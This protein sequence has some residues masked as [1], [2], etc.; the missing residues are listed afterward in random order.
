[1]L[2]CRWISPCSSRTRSRIP[3]YAL[4]R[5]STRRTTV[6]PSASTVAWFRVRDRKGVGIYT[7]TPMNGLLSS[8]LVRYTEIPLARIGQDRHDDLPLLKVAGHFHRGKDVGPGRDADQEPLLPV[9]TSGHFERVLVAH[10]DD[11]IENLHVEDRRDEAGADPLNGVGPGLP[12]LEDG[13]LGRF[14]GDHLDPRNL[15][16]ANLPAPPPAQEG[17]WFSFPP[18]TVVSGGGCSGVVV[19]GGVF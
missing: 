12:S 6:L 10:G 13:R 8:L 16:L 18:P 3:G 15:R 2:I 19:G 11:L 7:L 4:S 17:G 1:M 14:N 5:A 9:Q